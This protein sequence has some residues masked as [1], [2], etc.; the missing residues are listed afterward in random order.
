MLTAIMNGDACSS[1]LVTP[2]ISSASTS[3]GTVPVQYLLH[4]SASRSS[5]LERSSQSCFPSSDTDGNTNRAAMAASTN[6]ASP[7]FRK[8]TIVTSSTDTRSPVKSGSA[9]MLKM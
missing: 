9:R 5:G 2:V 8:T 4:I 1:T 7:R 3:S 6:P